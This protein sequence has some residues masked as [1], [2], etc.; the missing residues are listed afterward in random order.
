MGVGTGG[1]SWPTRVAGLIAEEGD[2]WAELL[3]L[4]GSLSAE[5]R[6]RPGYY[7]EGWSAKDAL[8]HIGSWLGLAGAVLERIRFGT[9][10]PEEIDIGALNE[11]FLQVNRDVAFRDVVSQG[12]AARNRM[13]QAWTALEGSSPDAEWWVSKAGPEHYGEHLPRMREWVGELTADEG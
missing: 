10:R 1:P 13:L 2:R 4:V 12:V 7:V 3:E 9:Y 11:R 5:K 6:E 8:A